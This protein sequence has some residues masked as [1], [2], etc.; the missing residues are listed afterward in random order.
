MAIEDEARQMYDDAIVIDGLNVSNW[1]S[2][3]VY[4]SLSSGA[5]RIHTRSEPC[6]GQMY[7]PFTQARGL[8]LKIIF[9]RILLKSENQ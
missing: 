2:P 8:Q 7:E 6:A 3:A 5:G 4:D 9:D 1:N